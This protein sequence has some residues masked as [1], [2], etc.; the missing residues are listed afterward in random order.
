MKNFAVIGNPI[1]HS[2]SPIMHE[3]IFNELEIDAK[4][5]KIILNENELMEFIEKIKNG[6]FDGINVTLPYKSKIIPFLDDINPRAKSIGAVNCIMKTNSH[7]IGNNTDWY[8]F[9][10]AMKR[11]KINFDASS[12]ILIGAG[13]AAKS[14]I[15]SLKN[16]GIKNITILIRNLDKVF[17]FQ[18]DIINVMPMEMAHEI[19]QSNSIIINT[20]P[21][22]MNSDKSPIKESLIHEHQILIDIIYNPL[23]TKFL[24]FG[25]KKGA[26]TINGLDMFIEQG[27]ASL[28]LWFGSSISKKV[29]FTQLKAYLG[30]QLC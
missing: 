24:E 8:G 17:E 18:D 14:I 10:M 13:G 11:N 1:I 28:D 12:I 19:I 5:E 27:M 9:S 7:V 3:W 6:K 2:M 16:L 29:N 26:L 4:Y 20:T 21:V 15:F 23:E 25:K 30:S 22:G